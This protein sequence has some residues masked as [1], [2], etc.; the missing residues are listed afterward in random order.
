MTKHTQNKTQSVE[1]LGYSPFDRLQHQV[2]R[3]F[4]DFS[5][6]FRW[7]EIF[8]GQELE[9]V[10]SMEV[11]HMDDKVVV[12]AELPG[13]D[14]VEIN[15]SVVDQTV[16]ISGEKKSETEHKDDDYFRSERSYGS[17]HRSVTLPF[18][19]DAEKVDA[20]FDKG[21]LTLTIERP[22]DQKKPRHK[23]KIRH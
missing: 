5:H 17:F 18:E 23:I 19:I 16:T 21:V 2:D 4:S 6:G 1:R 20:K 22:A 7:P 3:V 10:P 14:E 9:V 8:T 11:H 15:V 13:V 12:A